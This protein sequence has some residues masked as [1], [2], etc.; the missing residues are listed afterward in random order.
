MQENKWRPRLDRYCSNVILKYSFPLCIHIVF[1]TSCMS[2]QALNC[3]NWP[4]YRLATRYLRFFILINLKMALFN[5][6]FLLKK[7]KS[8]V[9]RIRQNIY[10]MLF[11]FILSQIWF[12]YIC[13]F[14]ITFDNIYCIVIEEIKSKDKDSFMWW[15]AGADHSPSPLIRC[16]GLNLIH[17]HVSRKSNLAVFLTL[18]L[19]SFFFDWF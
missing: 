5:F 10:W 9:W 15:P 13:Y 14:L 3:L 19:L 7:K 12:C 2:Y 17:K 1:G 16:N 18:V 8:K 6:F 11:Y 4:I